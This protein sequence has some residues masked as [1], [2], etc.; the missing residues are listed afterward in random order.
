MRSLSDTLSSFILSVSG[1]RSIFALESLPPE[2]PIE[3]SI[4]SRIPAGHAWAMISAGYALGEFYKKEY[5][6]PVRLA[7]GRDTRPTGARIEESLLKGLL[8]HQHIDI[9]YIGISAITEIMAFTSENDDID[10][11]IYVSASHNPS[12]YNGLKMGLS[13]GGCL[14]EE[15]SKQLIKILWNFVQ[16]SDAPNLL[17]KADTK[18]RNFP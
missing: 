3:D 12:G 4:D 15:K 7:L 13:E 11:F 1:W 9:A 18:K 6:R 17:E 5:N 14:N 10:G 2:T 8:L 16:S